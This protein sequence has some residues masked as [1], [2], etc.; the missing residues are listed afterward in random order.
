MRPLYLIG[1]LALLLILLAGVVI[2]SL[3]SDRDSAS[4]PAFPV[5]RYLQDPPLSHH[6]N[7]YMLEGVLLR[8]LE[9]RSGVGRLV[10]VEN[11][12]ANLRLP[13][14]I[15]ADVQDS[16]YV[17]QRYRLEIE[18]QEDRLLARHLRRL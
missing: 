7:R 10:V 2:F 3:R 4:H 6:G 1:S 14:L 15:P 18:V 17:G 9:A 5:N 12:E 8:Q 16:L 13:V 11:A